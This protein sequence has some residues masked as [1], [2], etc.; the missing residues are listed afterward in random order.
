MYEKLFDS[1]I[2][3][4]ANE[5][6][7]YNALTDAVGHKL[8][9]KNSGI[10]KLLRNMRDIEYTTS[11]MFDD[12]NEFLDAYKD[13]YNKS[14]DFCSGSAYEYQK[15]KAEVSGEWSPKIRGQYSYM[16]TALFTYLWTKY[17]Q[18]E[19]EFE[20]TNKLEK[21]MDAV[22]HAISQALDKEW[23][24]DQLK[25]KYII[26]PLKF[27]S[28]SINISLYEDWETRYVDK[29][30]FQEKD[31]IKIIIINAD[32]EYDDDKI[33]LLCMKLGE[34]VNDAIRDVTDN[35]ISITYLRKGSYIKTSLSENDKKKL[36]ES[37]LVC[38]LVG[39]S[40]DS[41]GKS[42]LEYIT[43]V[44]KTYDIK[45]SLFQKED[46]KYGIKS[47]MPVYT[48]AEIIGADIIKYYNISEVFIFLIRDIIEY[49]RDAE[50]S[51]SVEDK[52]LLINGHSVLPLQEHHLYN[53]E[54]LSKL[55]VQLL[56]YKELDSK[57]A[58]DINELEERITL[59]ENFI[60]QNLCL[61]MQ[62]I[63]D[64]SSSY[65]QALYYTEL[66]DYDN[67]NKILMNEELD[68][69]LKSAKGMMNIERMRI[70]EYIKAKRLLI[71][72][73]KVTSPDDYDK[74]INLYQNLVDVS[75]DTGTE[76]SIILEYS[77]YLFELGKYRE[78]LAEVRKLINL[79]E[80]YGDK[81]VK[82]ITDI[83]IHI[84][85][86]L[87]ELHKYDEAVAYYIKAE[88]N[89][90]KN[91]NNRLLSIK[92]NILIA[93]AYFNMSDAIKMEEPLRKAEEIARKEGYLRKKNKF[94]DKELE[95]IAELYHYMGLSNRQMYDNQNAITQYQH[96]IDSYQKIL[97]GLD[98]ES[99]LYRRIIVSLSR[100][101]SDIGV[102]YKYLGNFEDAIDCYLKSL[103]I[104]RELYKDNPYKYADGYATININIGLYYIEEDKDK[105]IKYFMEAESARFNTFHSDKDMGDRYPGTLAKL[106][107]A[108][109]KLGD[110]EKAKNLLLEAYRL[111]DTFEPIRRKWLYTYE[112]NCR[113]VMAKIYR[114]LDDPVESK[115]YYEESLEIWGNNRDKNPKKA[116]KNIQRIQDEFK[117]YYNT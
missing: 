23:L 101:Y 84:G 20:R 17:N 45:V 93:Q 60:S 12:L 82:E 44:Y 21:L 11:G 28:S 46:I 100:T 112:A 71:S 102:A 76:Y 5:Y 8:Y 96:S 104:R 4:I 19:N 56:H 50:F 61:S 110:I 75:I 9:R 14:Y 2:M 25:D 116:E 36:V 30:L 66:F 59:Y 41:K 47:L 69:N 16:A 81:K 67:A 70:K 86:V 31:D 77:Q 107:N 114:A 91:N 49:Y 103:N 94:S 72:N 33:G 55:R 48:T 63:E 52:T 3:A 51:I 40:I 54:V 35:R 43:T 18:I 68:V 57:S 106:G 80:L 42:F 32:Q 27:I 73:I 64:K 99:S 88:E 6:L 115:K 113:S 37:D 58:Y 13:R 89:S 90:F 109:R 95:V 83:Y 74:I 97:D 7:E 38:F 111:F 15:Q 39:K 24:Y 85:K 22:I 92:C 34:A 108:Y 26:D 78:S 79:Y 65:N 62:R 98:K 105:A 53:N 10:N 117:D 87:F 29:T 1:L